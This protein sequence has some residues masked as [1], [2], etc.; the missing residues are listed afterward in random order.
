MQ[1]RIGCNNFFTNKVFDKDRLRGSCLRVRRVQLTS[2]SEQVDRKRGGCCSAVEVAVSV[3]ARRWQLHTIS[4]RAT[5]L[6][7]CTMEPRAQWNLGVRPASRSSATLT[8]VRRL[9]SC[10]LNQFHPFKTPST[11]RSD[12][13]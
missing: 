4:P 12:G 2:R 1:R 9:Q 8:A 10:F 3:D 11:F 5:D 7:P 6:L 13:G